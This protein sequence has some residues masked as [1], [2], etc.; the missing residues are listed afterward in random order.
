MK[1]Q[2]LLLIFIF[3]LLALA[4]VQTRNEQN[5]QW[6]RDYIIQPIVRK[7]KSM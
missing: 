6:L 4:E 7:C 1:I 3:L 2:L 5:S